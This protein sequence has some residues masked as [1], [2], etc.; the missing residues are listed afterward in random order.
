M[1]FQGIFGTTWCSSRHVTNQS[2]CWNINATIN[3]TQN[4]RLLCQVSFSVTYCY[5]YLSQISRFS[6]FL[7]IAEICYYGNYDSFWRRTFQWELY[8]NSINGSSAKTPRKILLYVILAEIR[9]STLRF[10]WMNFLRFFSEVLRA[11]SYVNT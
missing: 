9:F 8:L 10:F 2:K 1:H 4:L 5:S 7:V 11:A 6:F 3:I